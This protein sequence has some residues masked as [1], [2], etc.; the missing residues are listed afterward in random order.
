MLLA[1]ILV[2]VYAHVLTGYLI[3]E[4]ARDPYQ[5][6]YYRIF[7]LDALFVLGVWPIICLIELGCIAVI[8]ARKVW[9]R[10]RTKKITA[11]LET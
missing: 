1:L 7:W 10:F 6:H 2:S 8:K 4:K 3:I 11:K 5:D 9:K